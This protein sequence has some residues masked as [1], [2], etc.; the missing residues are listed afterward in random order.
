VGLA[1]REVE[2][3]GITTI[4]LSTIP[5]LTHA[6][7]VPRLAGIEH[8]FG[9]TMGKAGDRETQRA[10]LLAALGAAETMQAPGSIVHLP[11]EWKGTKKEAK[12]EPK[13]PPPIT[14]HL[15]WHPWELPKLFSRDIPHGM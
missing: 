14:G 4:A 8:P 5:D 13:I 3:A 2:R 10:V 11:F 15:K 7:S 9:Q 1:Q 6:V 12:T